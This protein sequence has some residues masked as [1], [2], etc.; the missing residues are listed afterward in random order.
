MNENMHIPVM[1]NETIDALQV[2]PGGIYIDVTLGG[3]GHFNKILEKLEGKGTI[4]GIDK[5]EKAIISFKDKIKGFEKTG[6]IHT[7]ISGSLKILLINRNYSDLLEIL[8]ELDIDKVDGIIADLGL[9]TNQ[10]Q[11]GIGLSYL[12]DTLLD[13]RMETGLKVKASDLLNGLFEKELERLFSELGNIPFAKKLTKEVIKQRNI[14]PIMKTKQLTSIIQKI[15]PYEY[16]KGTNKHP[17]AKVFQALRIAVNHEL[18]DLR[19]LLPQAF[20]A[21]APGG[22]LVVI[23]FHSGEDRIVKTYFRNLEQEKSIEYIFKLQKPA[24]DEI[25]KNK[26]S[27]SAKLRAIKKI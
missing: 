9:A 21:L 27:H 24:Q 2:R 15:V 6:N 3:G 23:S 11:S 19:Q 5:D 4:I 1:L 16:R 18:V 22:R 13:M 25:L 10:Y 8:K 14:Q 7:K 12:E 17:E 26:R 20:E